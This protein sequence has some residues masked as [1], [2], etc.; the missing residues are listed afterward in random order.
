M[1]SVTIYTRKSNNRN[2]YAGFSCKG[3]AGYDDYGHDIVCS[4]M[5]MLVINTINSIEKLTE[6]K[7]KSD[8]NEKKGIINVTFEDELSDEARLLMDSMILGINT[9]VEEY[10][11]GYVTLTTKEV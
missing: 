7:F 3:H 5:S 1:I 4:A 9:V 11:K 8:S 6:C 10:G 2:D